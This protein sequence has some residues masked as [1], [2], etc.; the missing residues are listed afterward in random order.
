MVE[1][2]CTNH[3]GAVEW[4]NFLDQSHCVLFMVCSGFLETQ[5]SA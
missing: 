2:H 5:S 4:I 1:K 3:D